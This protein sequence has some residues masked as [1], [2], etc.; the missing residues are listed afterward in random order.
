MFLG[1]WPFFLSVHKIFSGAKGLHKSV[2]LELRKMQ[3]GRPIIKLLVI[4]PLFKRCAS[5]SSGLN[6]FHTR[7][8]AVE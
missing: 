3:K 1:V 4:L 5:R 8:F 7:L 6:S 2:K